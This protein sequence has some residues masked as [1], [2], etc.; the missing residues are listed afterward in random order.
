MATSHKTHRFPKGVWSCNCFLFVMTDS[1]T[2]L[3]VVL[4]PYC[5][6]S[7]NIRSPPRAERVKRPYC[8]PVCMSSLESIGEIDTKR[9]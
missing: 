6:A 9:E 2:L 7:R 8:R 1:H 3:F 4:Y 5:I